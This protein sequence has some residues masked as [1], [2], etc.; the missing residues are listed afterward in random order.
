MALES[1]HARSHPCVIK[2]F[3]FKKRDWMSGFDTG[4]VKGPDYPVSSGELMNLKHPGISENGGLASHLKRQ[5]ASELSLA[6]DDILMPD[7]RLNETN[8]PGTSDG[9]LHRNYREESILT[10]RPRKRIRFAEPQARASLEN[11]VINCDGKDGNNDNEEND[12]DK[13]NSYPTGRPFTNGALFDG[14][15]K[16]KPLGSHKYKGYLDVFSKVNVSTGSPKQKVDMQWKV[17]DDRVSRT[18][19]HFRGCYHDQSDW[20][21]E[22]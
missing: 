4:L 5:R 20:E 8:E 2:W 18:L 22:I 12:E 16:R 7:S 9:N 19:R 14:R 3:A 1:I 6:S 10:S 11:E 15:Q 17:L 13:E 21:Y